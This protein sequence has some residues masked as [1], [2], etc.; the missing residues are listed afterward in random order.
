MIKLTVGKK[1][2]VSL[3]FGGVFLA[4][5]PIRRVAGAPVFPD[6]E[7]SAGYTFS[8]DRVIIY[9]DLS[10]ASAS[11]QQQDCKDAGG[12]CWDGSR[13]VACY[14]D[15]RHRAGDPYVVIQRDGD[16]L[17]YYRPPLRMRFTTN[18]AADCCTSSAYQKT[19]VGTANL[20]STTASRSGQVFVVPKGVERITGFKATANGRVGGNGVELTWRFFEYSGDPAAPASPSDSEGAPLAEGRQWFPLHRDREGALVD[21]LDIPVVPGGVYYL[22]FS[23]PEDGQPKPVAYLPLVFNQNC[24]KF[25]ADN[26]CPSAPEES[27][28]GPYPEGS[29]FVYETARGVAE[30]HCLYASDD[31]AYCSFT[32]EFDADLAN[33]TIWGQPVSPPEPDPG[34]LLGRVMSESRPGVVACRP[35]FYYYGSACAPDVCQDGQC[36]GAPD[37]EVTWYQGEKS[38][39]VNADSCYPVSTFIAQEDRPR[40]IFEMPDPVD[41]NPACSEEGELITIRVRADSAQVRLKSWA[42]ATYR[43]V[44]DRGGSLPESRQFATFEN[45]GPEQEVSVRFFCKGDYRWNHLYL[46]A[47]EAPV[48]CETPSFS[49]GA[50][51]RKS[52][53]R[54]PLLNFLLNLLRLSPPN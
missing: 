51:P 30:E 40:F 41:A 28:Q 20:G 27:C 44:N 11:W 42:Y 29:A 47:D 32:G 1:L 12:S 38:R 7:P 39:S 17:P 25:G 26:R 31:S 14:D 9:P 24:D 4:V 23:E 54:S 50:T 10:A 46:Y 53:R 36:C 2:V 19:N 34:I 37:Y 35:S 3:L 6:F 5:P 48:T 43:S 22:E 49:V 16:G 21:G 33:L 45:P 15:F 8:Q 18:K 52:V 13:E